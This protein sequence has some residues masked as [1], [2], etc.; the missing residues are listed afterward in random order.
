MAYAIPPECPFRGFSWNLR[1]LIVG[2]VLLPLA[3]CELPPVQASDPTT[4]VTGSQDS[5]PTAI[6]ADATVSYGAGFSAG[7]MSLN[8]SATL[9]GSRLRL[10]DLGGNEASSA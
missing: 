8:G 6:P 5:S 9:N 1:S 3:G 7:N 10:T 4:P 2:L